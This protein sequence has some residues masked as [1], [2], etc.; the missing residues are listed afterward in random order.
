[1]EFSGFKTKIICLIT[2]EFEDI[3]MIEFESSNE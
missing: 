3:I 2:S 1:M